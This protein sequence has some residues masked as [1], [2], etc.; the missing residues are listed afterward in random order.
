MFCV[1]QHVL[2]LLASYLLCKLIQPVLQAMLSQEQLHRLWIGP[3]LEWPGAMTRSKVHPVDQLALNDLIKNHSSSWKH[4]EGYEQVAKSQA[5]RGDSLACLH[6]FIAAL[7]DL[8]PAGEVNTSQLK[9]AIMAAVFT[10]PDLNNTTQKNDI[11]CALRID[12]ITTVLYHLR[13]L[14]D[15]VK[16]QQMSVG[17]QGAN[18]V[19]IKKLLDK[20]QPQV[21][22]L[23]PGVKEAALETNQ[24][25]IQ[26]AVDDSLVANEDSS[27]AAMQEDSNADNEIKVACKTKPAGLSSED[28]KQLWKGG[29]QGSSTTPK[30]LKR[31]APKVT[32]TKK[33]C[34]DMCQETSAEHDRT[35]GQAIFRKEYYKATNSYGI[36][37]FVQGKAKQIFSLSGKTGWSKDQ[38]TAL[39]D[40][41]LHDLSKC[42]SVAEEEEIEIIAKH[43]LLHS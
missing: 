18:A 26:P 25:E 22:P 14:L 11:W 17:S 4:M 21:Q 41:V 28:F 42:R 39:A 2:D 32:P 24:E 29:G 16:F 30:K 1:G 5:V 40:K 38:L 34:K 19:L 43:K 6:N 12:R 7:L 3:G 8:A 35:R 15:P 37:K 23:Q 27:N 10:S 31:K 13:R 20:L 33:V 36:K 9:T